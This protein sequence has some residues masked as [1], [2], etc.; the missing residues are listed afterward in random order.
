MDDGAS[1]NYGPGAT[2]GANYDFESVMLHELGHGH[3]LGHVIEPGTDVM[4]YAIPNA[5]D[6]RT[7]TA[8]NIAGG[9]TVMANS[10]AA[11]T[12]PESA[13]ILLTAA[14]CPLAC[15]GNEPGN[16][17]CVN[18]T[19]IPVLN[20]TCTTSQSNWCATYEG[21]ETFGCATTQNSV[22]YDFVLTG[23]NNKIQVTFSNSTIGGDVELILWDATAGC[24]SLSALE[25]GA[26]EGDYDICILEQLQLRLCRY[27][28][29][30][31]VFVYPWC[32][33]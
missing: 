24:G 31:M 29:Y 20:G 32:W 22:W 25:A 17:N 1:W 5:T 27:R 9:N 2:V 13:H 33:K 16:D 11:N 7:L 12:C 21:F 14:S 3:Q 10:T 23:A 18:S 28:E 6:K 8:N 19:N 26:D 4:H 15:A 30:H